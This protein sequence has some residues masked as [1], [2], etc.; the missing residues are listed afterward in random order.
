MLWDTV[1]AGWTIFGDPRS[2]SEDQW[3]EWLGEK[4]PLLHGGYLAG[5]GR[6]IFLWRAEDL[7]DRIERWVALYDHAYRVMDWLGF[8]ES[9]MPGW[10]LLAFM[11][12]QW[13]RIEVW[14]S[15]FKTYI[16]YWLTEGLRPFQHM[17][18]AMAKD[19]APKE[20]DAVA[21][22]CPP[23][24]YDIKDHNREGKYPE[25]DPRLLFPGYR[26]W[27][28]SP[29]TYMPDPLTRQKLEAIQD[30]WRSG[31][32]SIKVK[33]LDAEER[34]EG[35][36][37]VI[38]E[39]LKHPMYR[40]IHMAKFQA[41]K[42]SRQRLAKIRDLVNECSGGKRA[43]EELLY[44]ALMENQTESAKNRL[45]EFDEALRYAKTH[46]QQKVLDKVYKQVKAWFDRRRL[47]MPK[48]E[49]EWRDK[50]IEKR[51]SQITR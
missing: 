39:V 6:S 50:I 11:G 44:W 46:T 21:L 4:I 48:V 43:V 29:S 42:E 33:G 37:R 18:K 36:R 30:L 40:Q 1:A 2:L 16:A 47:P 25:F 14:L 7:G 34:A 8:V 31:D 5:R 12:G 24:S 3:N 51:I 32:P 49:K 13:E 19:E 22:F 15:W 9:T 20:S 38:E 35:A 27:I 41:S 17:V 28:V 26:R 23:S 10:W 45:E